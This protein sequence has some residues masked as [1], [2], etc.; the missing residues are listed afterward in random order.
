M[1]EEQG[2]AGDEGEG[3]IIA[4]LEGLGWTRRGDTNI[5][6]KCDYKYHP[7]RGN[8]YGVDGY[9]SYDGPYRDK[10]RGIII[11]SKNIKWSSYGP[12]DFKKWADSTLEKVEAVPESDD[13]DKYLNFDTPRIVNAGILS[14]WTRDEDNYNHDT[15]KG[16]LDE[17]PIYPKKRKKFQILALG[18]KELN[19]LASIH[20]EFESIANR[21]NT[22]SI[23]FFYPPRND[24][25]SARTSLLNL[26]YLLSDYVFA[27]AE[28]DQSLPNM[29][30]TR[31]IGVIFYFDALELDALNFMYRAVMEH[32]MEDVD[33]L[34][35][36][37]Y[38]DRGEDIQLASVKREFEDNGLP[39]QLSGDGPEIKMKTLKQVNYASHADTLQEEN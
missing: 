3:R 16:Y 12:K 30:V 9:M 2:R 33:E 39:E 29:T 22:N 15:F 19:R 10:E 34:W 8:T 4:L 6:V 31:D 11:E 1:A 21:D 26:E 18:N 32:G 5:D 13:F 23:E 27:R 36:Y 25:H 38:D 35:V 20:S 24:S 17:I 7:D 28:I 14:V 37:M